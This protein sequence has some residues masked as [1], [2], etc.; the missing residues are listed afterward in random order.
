MKTIIAFHSNQIS[1]TGTEIALFDYAAG[2]ED[3]LGGKSII[4][5][6]KNSK[7][8]EKSAIDKFSKRFE[9]I[10]YDTFSDVDSHLKRHNASLM[11]MIKSGKNDGL[12]SRVVPTMVHAVF[13]TNPLQAHGASYAYVSEWLSRRCS[14]DRIPCVPHMVE[15]PKIDED[16][17]DE[18]GIARSDIVIGSYGGRF[19]FDIL[20][21]RLAIEEL[22]STSAGLKFI[23]MNTEPFTNQP[24][25][26][27]L[28]GSTDLD[29]KVK[30][31]NTC[32][33]MLHARRLGESFGL[34]CAE[35]SICNKP[36]I[37]Y[38]HNKH[39]HH[40]DILGN[41]AFYFSDKQSL[42]EIITSID[43][44]VTKQKNWD[45]YSQRY[46]QTRVMSLFDKH[47][48]YPASTNSRLDKPNLDIDVG[49]VS[50]FIGLKFSM[51]VNSRWYPK[52]VNPKISL[53]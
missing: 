5:H 34:A 15:L 9:V 38:K 35:F 20:E 46:N 53:V 45:C 1:V 24:S 13:P 22:L 33:A 52:A 39:T 48:I 7:N 14:A 19:N 17:R 29:Y 50:A 44:S 16:L 23:F 18:L 6:N 8:N 43:P 4:L 41:K 3:V 36:I 30:F 21:A 42:I 32:D 49:A 51:F 25:A 27:F 47:L 10:A 31:I 37:T 2:N 28:P 26:I 11:Y 12:I 40:H